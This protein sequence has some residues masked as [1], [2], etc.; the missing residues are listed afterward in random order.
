M[1]LRLHR[2]AHHAEAHHRLAA[3]RD[4]ARNDRLVG[5]LRG[6][7]AVRMPRL[8]DEGAAAVLQRD[9]LDHHAGAEAHV[10]RLD[11]GDHHS[12]GV[13]RGQVHR[14]AL[15]RRAVAEILRPAH[16]DQLGARLQI[17]LVEKLLRLHFGHV[18]DVGHV[19]PGVGEGDLQRLDLQVQAVGAVHGVRAD[20]EVLQ[21]PEGHQRDDALAV[22]RNL[23]QGVA[24][25]VH[26]E[27]LHP[28]GLVGG[29]VGGAH[30]AAVLLRVRLELLRELAAIE[31]LAP[32]G[33]DLLQDLGVR[34]ELEALA[35]ARRAAAGHEIFREAGLVLQL[36][37][38]LLPLLRNGRRDQEPLAAVADRALEELLER[39][40]AEL[41]M[42]L[43]PGLH[44]AGHGDA[45]PAPHRH[46][47]LSLE[48][49]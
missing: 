12:R 30:D 2:A 3:A 38:L 32:A 13:R 21:H 28:V 48:V 19:A 20:V 5:A 23:V 41:R 46:R 37:D 27:R 4:E 42:Q 49:L 34:R 29:E 10:V 40:L 47:L 17:L 33:G 22:G 18:L 36:R 43:D 7:D 11:V 8:D 16:V 26:L 9:A 15:G 14:A 6:P 44:A 24:A 25:I 39:Q 35:G 45:V 1:S 31:R